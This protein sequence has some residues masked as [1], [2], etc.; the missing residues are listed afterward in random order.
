MCYYN[1]ELFQKPFD[2]KKSWYYKSDFG[3]VYDF[4]GHLLYAIH[5]HPIL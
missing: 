3:W 2:N 1:F 5:T 4:G